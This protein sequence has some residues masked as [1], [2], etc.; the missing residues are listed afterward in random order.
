MTQMLKNPSYHRCIE[1]AI[2]AYADHL[3]A[4]WIFALWEALNVKE[5]PFSWVSVLL[6]V[7][8]AS[9]PGWGRNQPQH[10]QNDRRHKVLKQHAD[11]INHSTTVTG[12]CKILKH[13]IP[14]SCS[15]MNA[16]KFQKILGKVYK[17]PE[18]DKC[19]KVWKQAEHSICHS[20]MDTAE[21]WNI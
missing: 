2:V 8:K 17:H 9:S 6:D 21:S 18:Q 5:A 13:S 16:A 12:H 20:M 14:I 10:C 11:R 1:A 19:H 7:S 15:I 3:T 4:C